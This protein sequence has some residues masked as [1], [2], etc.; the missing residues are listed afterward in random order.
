M[1][2]PP[3][4]VVRSSFVAA[5]DV[6]DYPHAVQDAVAR[7]IALAAGVMPGRVRVQILAGSVTMESTVDSPDEKSA[8]EIQAVLRDGIFSSADALSEATGLNVEDIEEKPTAQ[9]RTD[10]LP[11]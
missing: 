4:W 1:P 9:E 5:G 11:P 6:A 8:L 3:A 10:T 7:I 2:A